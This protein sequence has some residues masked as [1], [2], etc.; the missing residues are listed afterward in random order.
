MYSRCID[1]VRRL[2]LG[3]YSKSAVPTLHSCGEV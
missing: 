1:E 3:E 2:F